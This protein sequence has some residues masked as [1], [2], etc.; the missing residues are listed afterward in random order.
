MQDDTVLEHRIRS[1]ATTIARV[2]VDERLVQANNRQQEE[3]QLSWKPPPQGWVSVQVDG[4]V[5]QPGSKAAAG[6]LIRDWTKRCLGAFV[7]NLGSF[8]IT[9]AEL[10]GDGRGTSSSMDARSQKDPPPT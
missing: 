8:T 1:S 5:R 2:Q 7:E 10:K 9:R 4:S 3:Q 6:G